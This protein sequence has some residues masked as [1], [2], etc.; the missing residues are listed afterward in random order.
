MVMLIYFMLYYLLKKIF[1]FEFLI[2]KTLI[3]ST[4]EQIQKSVQNRGDIFV[5][6]LPSPSFEDLKDSIDEIEHAKQPKTEGSDKTSLKFK[7]HRIDL[8]HREDIDLEEIYLVDKEIIILDHFE[9][10][11]DELSKLRNNLI[12]IERLKKEG[13]QIVIFSHVSPRQIERIYKNQRALHSATN[14]EEVSK[15]MPDEDLWSKLLTSFQVLHY[16]LKMYEVKEEYVSSTDENKLQY[17]LSKLIKK[18]LSASTYFKN[19]EHLVHQKYE[20]IIQKHGTQDVSQGF[21]ETLKEEMILYIQ[22][23]AQTYY[24]SLWKTCY[25]NQRFLL[26]DLAY[27]GI[28]NFKDGG[29]VLFLMKK[30]LLKFDNGIEIMNKSFRNFIID[31]IGEEDALAMRKEMEQKGTWSS[32]RIV[33]VIV[34]ISLLIFILMVNKGSINQVSAI[35]T[36]SVALIGVL[37]RIFSFGSGSS[38]ISD[39]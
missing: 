5:I 24:F 22:D 39:D 19:V 23:I 13:K 11:C 10:A 34:A 25:K 6:G 7:T 1:G 9:Y 38:F 12:L 28:A 4:D 16:R 36:G 35:I 8:Q 2:S 29:T 18:E 30:G 26:Y 15:Y 33:L 27:D 14:R 3:A 21:I 17:Q 31:A 32:T 20:E 37:L